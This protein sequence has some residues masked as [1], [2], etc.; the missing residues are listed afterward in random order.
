MCHD[1]L[2]PAVLT[3]DSSCTDE[4]AQ[5][6]GE[7]KAN[8][9]NENKINF[10]LWVPLGNLKKCFFKSG[11]YKPSS[12]IINL[13]ST[14]LFGYRT[15]LILLG[16]LGLFLYCFTKKKLPLLLKLITCY[17]LLWYFWNSFVYRNMEIRFLLPADILLLIPA[18]YVFVFLFE[19]LF[20]PKTA[21]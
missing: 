3:R 17:F 14:V 6:W 12:G 10:Y 20:P 18:A 2:R 13:M 15:F 16:L 7:L 19:K 21:A 11:L 4:I 5:L 8:Q 9:V 1:G